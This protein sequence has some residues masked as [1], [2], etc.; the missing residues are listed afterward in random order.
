MVMDAFDSAVNAAENRGIYY[1]KIEVSANYVVFSKGVG[2]LSYI[3]NQ[4]D[5][6][7]RRTEVSFVLSPIDEMGMANLVQRSI[8]AESDEWAKL[9]WPSLRDG[10]NVKNLRDTDGKFVK[11]HLIPN[12]RSWDDKK[13]GEKRE[14]T[15]MKFTAIYASEAACKTAFIDD[16]NSV[17]V[18]TAPDSTAAAMAVDMTPNAVNPERETA[19]AFLPALV[20]SSAGNPTM[21]ATMITGMP[22]I[23][24]FFTIDSPEVRE[25][26]VAA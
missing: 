3:E 11:I 9:V 21:L 14:G 10:C 2:K 7:D 8:I 20:K 18:P 5:A 24:K 13:T 17:R 15:T 23:S 6:K 19:K 4:H 22:I 25:L 12:G 16:G 1:G 26:M